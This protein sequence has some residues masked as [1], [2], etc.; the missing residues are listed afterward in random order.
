MEKEKKFWWGILIFNLLIISTLIYFK[1]DKITITKEKIVE[2]PKIE[3]KEKIVNNDILYVYDGDKINYKVWGKEEELIA[4]NEKIK[5]LKNTLWENSD[6]YINEIYGIPLY[7]SIKLKNLLLVSWER[8]SNT[9]TTTPVI[10]NVVNKEVFLYLHKDDIITFNIAWN[11]A[12]KT[13]LEIT[14]II[15]TIIKQYW[16]DIPI[17][18][19][20]INDT[21]V[22]LST[23]VKNFYTVLIK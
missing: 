6:I 20:K 11:V 12:S 3:Y 17:K 15:E 7:K 22:D 10:N 18:V 2:V 1:S 8:K 9:N 16:W 19:T 4:S 14:P 23:T 21:T 13:Y 5:T